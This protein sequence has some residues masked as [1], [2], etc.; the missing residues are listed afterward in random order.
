M[1]GVR[2]TSYEIHIKG[3]VSEQLLGA[4]EGMDATVQS[5][6]TV[7]RGP[8]LDQAALHGLLDRIQALGLELVEVRRLPEGGGGQGEGGQGTDPPAEAGGAGEAGD[9]R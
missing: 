4:F 9:P 2:R 8:V 5:V 6:E 1:V 3:R 7:L